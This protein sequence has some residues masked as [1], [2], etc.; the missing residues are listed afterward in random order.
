MFSKALLT[1]TYKKGRPGQLT[2]AHEKAEHHRFKTDY[3]FKNK[4]IVK[5]LYVSRLIQH[6][7]IIK[8][9]ENQLQRLAEPA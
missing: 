2:E 1:A 7:L 4:K 5:A 8:T 9:L 3:L 6:F